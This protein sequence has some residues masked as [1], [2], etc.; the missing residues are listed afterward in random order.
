MLPSGT[1]GVPQ[2][3]V[4]PQV[5]VLE[6]LPHAVKTG[7]TVYVSAMMPLD[8]TGRLVGA[9]DL[10]AQARQA[11][12]N[13]GAVMRA[14]R[15]VP[16]DVVRATV[17]IRDLTPEKVAVVRGALL[18]G[19]DRAAPPALTVIGVSAL[20]VPGA[21]VAIDATAQL[22]GEFPDRS[23]DRKPCLLLFLLPELNPIALGIVEPG[24]VTIRSFLPFV[25]GDAK[26]AEVFDEI[27]EVLHAPGD[28][29][30]PAIV[31]QWVL[32]LVNGEGSS[33]R[34]APPLVTSRFAA[35]EDTEM[36]FVP[37]HE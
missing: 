10:A 15:G 8:S 31:T 3:I 1:A 16:G 12:G 18:D 27:V 5:P 21:D 7:N 22:R 25:H 6:G 9:G 33:A 19:L 29:D 24:I 23:R 26:V 30:Q 4:A 13:L 32:R 20:A 37:L 17:Y 35:E 2:L 28:F 14:A 11:I 36:F 34:L